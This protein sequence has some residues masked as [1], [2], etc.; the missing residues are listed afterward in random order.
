M[1]VDFVTHLR[2]KSTITDLVGTRTYVGKLPQQV[3]TLPVLLVQR[4]STTHDRH[5]SGASGVATSRLQLD[6]WA[7]TAASARAVAEAVRVAVDGDSSLTMGTTK[8]AA[9]LDDGESSTYEPADDGSD[10]GEFRITQ[11]WI[12]HHA[13]TTPSL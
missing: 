1:E 7:A 12:V 9:V 2:T 4:I 5:L 3:T 13:E 10:T 11:D 8:V 6:V